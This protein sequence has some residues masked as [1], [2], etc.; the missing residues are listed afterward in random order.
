[1][2][3]TTQRL[4]FLLCLLCLVSSTSLSLSA[5]IPAEWKAAFINPPPAAHPRTWWHWTQGNVTKEG[6]TKDLE[7][8]KRVGIAGFQLADVAA[9]NGQT[10]ERP[11]V[12]GSPE[13]KDA[14]HFAASEAK[15]LGLEMAVFSSPGW[16]LTGGPWVKP[17]QAMKKLV[18]S[19]THITGGTVFNGRLLQPPAQEG[20]GPLLANTP[21]RPGVPH[22]YA[23]C[24]VIAYRTTADELEANHTLPVISTSSGIVDA[25]LLTDDN[26]LTGISIKATG[27]SQT[28]WLQL[29]YDHPILARSIT[30][31][32]SKGI[33]FGRVMAGNDSNHLYTLTTIPGKSGYRGGNIRT[34]TFPETRAR[35]FRIELTN[36]PARPGEVISQVT[37]AVDSVYTLS[38]VQLHADGRVNRWEDK[39]GFNFL[40]EYS[41]VGTSAVPASAVIATSDIIDISSHMQPDGTLNWE[42][43]AGQWT[44][45]RFGYALTGA[46][47]R[48]ATPAALG[49]EVDKMSKQHVEAYLQYYTGLLQEATG[50]LYGKSLQY[51]MMDSWEAGIQNWTDAMIVDFK[52]RRGYDPTPYLPV[53]AGHI[54]GSA[55]ESDRFLWDFRRTLVDLIAENH[56]GTVTDYLNK[57]GIQTYSEAGGVSLESIEDALLNKKYVNIPMGEFWVKD[58]H[59]SSMYYEDMRGAAS[60][61]HV[62]GKGLVAAEAFTGGNYESPATL[63]KIADYWF[64]QGLNRLV[65]HTSA[66]QP[67]DTKPGNTMVGT[68]INRNIT[69]AENAGPFITYLSRCSFMLQK[70]HYVADIAYL[71]N[72]GA[73]S[74]MPFWGA[75]LQPSKPD[76][77]EFDYIN[78]D[79][80]L[81]LMTVDADGKLVLP[82]GMHYSILVLPNTTQMSLPVLARIKELTAEGATIVGPKPTSAPGLSAGVAGDAQLTEMA[83]QLWADLDGSSRTT[84]TYGKGHIFWGTPL[85][86]VLAA[87]AVPRDVTIERLPEEIAWTHRREGNTDIYYIVNRT[88]T[89]QDLTIRFR[90]S[91]KEV[92]LWNPA[93]GSINPASYTLHGA[94]T[95]VSLHLEGGQTLFVVF[96]GHASVG[97]RTVP[98][99]RVPHILAELTGSW[100]LHF[101]ANMGAP[102]SILW[103]E[104]SAWTDSKEEGIRYFSGT[105]TYTKHFIIKRN[106]LQYG[107]GIWLNLGT[108]ADMAEVWINGK[109]VGLA[110]HPPYRLLINQQLTPGDNIL[111]IKVT[112]E[113]TNRLLGDKANPDKKVLDNYVNPFGGP[114]KLTASGLMGP[115]QLLSVNTAK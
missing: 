66:H 31:A 101:P 105:A 107:T 47:N 25:A 64:S 45:L 89:V 111:E 26:L 80:L 14:V 115:V 34:Y 71:L 23:D 10:V 51:V 27:P 100:Q 56:Y 12:Y 17:E 58:L 112:N 67:L 50:Q 102:A 32:G 57:Q 81:N 60:A 78:A 30:I 55:E 46:K 97:T 87:I 65:F 59:P 2:R 62:Y 108:V 76:G 41:G 86:E 19:E 24:A 96:S 75:G 61:S 94:F 9:G 49:Y 39:A 28:A 54:V 91:G 35:Y 68:H 48:P 99:S 42:A 82:G 110:W 85:Q 37:T 83:W 38:E 95:Q 40:F 74:T 92:S 16:S 106:W 5:Q 90:S 103:P 84:R 98:A 29:S 3:Y 4:L 7:W 109:R 15:R 22:F 53:M 69:W 36:D 33:P 114:Y 70:G 79:V 43:P 52:K 63:K 44:I 8:M 20:A 88:D 104:L 1:M 21:L 13:W 73:P 113:W 11:L 6:V 72:E 93:E 18:W 77:Y